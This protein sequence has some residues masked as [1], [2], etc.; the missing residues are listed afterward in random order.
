MLYGRPTRIGGADVFG[1][2]D[3]VAEIQGGECLITSLAALCDSR[4]IM[5]TTHSMALA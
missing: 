1:S 2:V 5:L 3:V 4:G